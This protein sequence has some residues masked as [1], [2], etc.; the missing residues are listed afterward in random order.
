MELINSLK[1]L[2]K[3]ITVLFAITGFLFLNGC[4]T[5]LQSVTPQ[6]RDRFAK[7]Q[8]T[9]DC[10]IRC[11]MSWNLARPRLSTLHLQEQWQTLADEVL[12]IGYLN[13][14]SYYYLGRAAEGL[15]YYDAALKYY[16]IS[17]GASTYADPYSLNHCLRPNFNN[18]SGIV[19][20]AALYPRIAAVQEAIDKKNINFYKE[21]R[22][23][24]AISGFPAQNGSEKDDPKPI[25]NHEHQSKPK[26]PKSK[27][28]PKPTA[29]PVQ[30]PETKADAKSS[31]EEWITPPPAS[32]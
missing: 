1:A 21:D 22:Y 12:R 14:L 23:S 27:H 16:R 2:K 25:K 15:G 26:K 9:L 24:E 6:D 31:N 29:V 11:D 18:C 13:D 5:A 7:G 30:M 20:P 32:R 4:A 3:A 28:Q 19:L 8:T 10:Q 17:G